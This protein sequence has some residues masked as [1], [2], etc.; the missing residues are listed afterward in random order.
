MALYIN[1]GNRGGSPNP[2]G[3]LISVL[4]LAGILAVIYM[5]VKGLI[6]YAFYITPVLFLL[7]LLI[8]SQVVIKYFT[9]LG[10]TLKTDVLIGIIKILF[11]VFT[12]FVAMSLLLKA[13]LVRKISKFAKGVEDQMQGFHEEINKRSEQNR[14]GETKHK[15][16]KNKHTDDEG[17]AEYEEIK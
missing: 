9:D 16:N 14:R 15:P 10:A 8:N 11:A 6:V 13:L 7:T 17:Y 12:P 4:M 5:V 2:F 3:S 1:N